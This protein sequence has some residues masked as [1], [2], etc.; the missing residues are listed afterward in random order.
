[1]LLAIDAGNTHTVLGLFDGDDMRA[2]WRVSTRVERTADELAVQLLALLRIEGLDATVVDG[3]IVASVVPD[4]DRI[5]DEAVRRYFGCTPTFV[6]PG[7]DHGLAVR[8]DSPAD[9]GADRIVNAVAAI[10]QF[11][12]PVLI[13]DFGTATTL[14]VVSAD[15][16][17]LGGTITPGIGVSAEALFRRAAK[18]RRVE[19]RR[20]ER[21]I[22]RSTAESIQSGLFFGYVGLVEG[23]VR[24][25]RAELGAPDAPVVATGGLAGVIA[26]DLSAVSAVEPWLTL[27]GLRILWNRRVS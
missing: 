7:F 6:G 10:A 19:I 5:L 12:T 1:M 20:P 15:G 9:V 11:G 24:R 26:P 18:L 3:V 17:Y 8:Y 16:E 13:L 27:S 14:D 2:H 4:L 21:V 22:G 25:A 23:L